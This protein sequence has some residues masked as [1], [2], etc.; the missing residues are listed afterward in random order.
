M[1]SAARDLAR[2]WNVQGKWEDQE[3]LYRSQLQF[4]QHFLPTDTSSQHLHIGQ[5][6][7]RILWANS[8]APLLVMTAEYT[9]P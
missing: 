4:L 3:K 1:H 7:E 5:A 2:W 8:E 6:D 9:E